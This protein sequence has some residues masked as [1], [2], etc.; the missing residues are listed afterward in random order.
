MTPRPMLQSL[1]LA[2]AYWLL[3]S[4]PNLASQAKHLQVS[5]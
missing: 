2:N 3:A 5:D 4:Y 1:C